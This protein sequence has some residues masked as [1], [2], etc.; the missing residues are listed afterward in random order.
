MSKDE[1]TKL[2]VYM[3]RRFNELETKIDKKAD[4]EPVYR[5][6][7]SILKRL[8]NH[9]YE[10]AAIKHQLQRH[11]GWFKQLAKNTGTELVPEP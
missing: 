11:E 3:E 10:L 4:A 5:A 7:D 9:D 1:F 6:L 2:F 8:D